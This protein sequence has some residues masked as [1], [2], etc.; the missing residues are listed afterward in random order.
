MAQKAEQL[1]TETEVN[2][3]ILKK[4]KTNIGFGGKSRKDIFQT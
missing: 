1:P 3:L 4:L 2:D